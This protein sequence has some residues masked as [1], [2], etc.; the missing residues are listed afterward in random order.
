MEKETAGKSGRSTGKQKQQQKISCC[1]K[2]VRS[3]QNK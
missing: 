1:T 2:I 3:K